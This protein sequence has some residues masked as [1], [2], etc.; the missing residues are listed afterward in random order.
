MTDRLQQIRE[1]ERKSH[2]DIY[3]NEQLYQSDS[4]LKKPIKTI[5]EILPMFHQYQ[6]L[7]VLDLG[8]GVGRNCISIASEF[9]TIPCEIDCVDI[10]ELAIE[11]L[12]ENA[13]EYGVETAIHGTVAPI[14]DYNIKE[15]HYDFIIAVSAL[16]HVDT[17]TSFVNKLQEIERGTRKN[18]IVCL[19]INTNVREYEKATGKPMPAQFEVNLATEKLQELLKDTFAGWTVIK[20]SIQEQQYD[21]PRE[22]GTSR[23]TT[24]VVTFVGRM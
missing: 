6:N 5:Q 11:K 24:N 21:I 16:E 8:C 12:Y 22:F 19:V 23:L 10:L 13:G 1:S 20:S 9:Q 7:T 2:I 14:E 3:S 15:N 4:W 17:K 18:G